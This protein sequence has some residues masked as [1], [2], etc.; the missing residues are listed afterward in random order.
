MSKS[1][2]IIKED[3]VNN[4]DFSKWYIVGD[5]ERI[6]VRRYRTVDSKTTWESYPSNL[7]K[8]LDADELQALVTRL[9][10]SY[11]LDRAA[12]ADRYKF[13]HSYIN[14]RS[15]A[16]FERQL[17][18]NITDKSKQGHVL[19][20]LNTYVFDFFIIQKKQ[21]D[22]ARWHLLENEWGDWLLDTDL[23]PSSIRLVVSTANRFNKFLT[24]KVYPDMAAP[25]KLEPIGK[26]KL[27]KI[28]SERAKEAPPRF[29]KPDTYDKIIKTAKVKCPDV[30]PNMLLARA[31]GLRISETLGL[32]KDKFLKDN[33]LID[34][35][36]DSYNGTELIRRAAKTN[37][38]RVPYWNMTAKEAWALVKTIKPMHPDTLIKKVNEHLEP[39]NHTSH[40]FRHTFITTALRLKN[41]HWKDVQKAAGH[42]DVRTTMSYDQDD[43]DLSDEKADLD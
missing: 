18:K 10:V 3:K 1:A 12:A 24:E 39:Y 29:I 30:L 13:D 43:R 2:K 21:P 42:T 35:Q 37:E 23:S 22:P 11:E 4:T 28:N 31:F 16:A 32:T 20:L 26:L 34:E 17:N 9:N 5:G 15:M 36:G 14:I 19:H 6:R 27:D 40:D 38:R 8:H 33:L 41:V 25:R 7:Y